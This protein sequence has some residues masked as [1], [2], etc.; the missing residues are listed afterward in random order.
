MNQE[1]LQAIFGDDFNRAHVTDFSYPPEEI[2]K[3]QVMISWA[4]SSFETYKF[5]TTNNQYFSI[6]LFNTDENNRPRRRKVLF[7]STHCIVLDD[8]K[9]KLPIEEVNR[10]PAPS[11]ILE[12]SHN[13]EQWGYILD[14][15]CTNRIQ[16]ENLLDGLVSKGLAPNG[17]DP[18]MRGVTRYVRLPD[19]YNHKRKRWIGG[20]PF[21][22]R[23]LLWEPSRKVSMQ[24][25][26]GPFGV[27]LDAS[28]RETRV[29]G[30]A[31][32]NDHPLLSSGLRIKAERSAGRFD[33]TCPWIDEH[34]DADDS[35]A[36]IFTNADGSLGF[37]CHHGACQDRTGADL[38]RS[39]GA[40]FSTRYNKWRVNRIF[41]D[42]PAQPKAEQPLDTAM[43]ELRQ[44]TPFSQ[45]ARDCAG[46]VLKIVDSMAPIERVHWHSEIRHI[47]KWGKP[48]FKSIIEGLRNSWYEK[49]TDAFIFEDVVFVGELN[50]FYDRNKRLFYSPEAYQNSF[51]HIDAEAKKRALLD[52][53]VKKVNR[54]DYAPKQPPIFIESDNVY[55][56]TWSDVTE[57][58]GVP[59]DVSRWL[60]HFDV[61]GWGEHRK[62]ILQW[63][64]FTLLY[65]ETKI[66]HM[67]LFGSKEGCGKDF[68][69]LPLI[70]ALG[71]NSKTIDGDE[72]LERYS[73]YLLGAKHLHINEAEMGEHQLAAQVGR[74]LKPLTS[75][76]P[77]TL[78]VREMYI[79]PM[80][81]R[82]IVNCTMTTNGQLPFKLTGMSRRIYALW[83]DLN[84]RDSNNEVL[85]EWEQYWNEQ[86]A[87]MYG[88]GF[89]N[90]IYYLRNNVDVSDFKYGNAPQVTDFLRSICNSSKSSLQQTVEAFIFNKVGNFGNTAITTNEAT[91]TLRSGSVIAPDLMYVDEKWINPNTVTS[92]L[93]A[94]TGIEKLSGESWRLR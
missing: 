57:I 29:D 7:A 2:P 93:S 6:S 11:W 1:F 25:L 65:P 91:A 86:W 45:E 4:G 53:L 85:P 56:N 62:H 22:C 18:G 74:K 44:Q 40:E 19:G 43:R 88:E 30:A 37:K 15:P 20:L 59:G 27:D 41:A 81:V 16:V 58:K 12:T 83:S 39:L 23:L 75:A 77:H 66:N 63:M 3:D 55:A 87:W 38:V 31:A 61:L 5:K 8:V 46:K 60:N 73:G 14:T 71:D 76:P 50:Q 47:M 24:Q 17:K 35:G 54:L 9:E 69:L 32:V 67:L 42:I 64:A 89:L 80:N 21:K 70:R 51:G 68:L 78:R 34:T 52:G 26:A 90:C 82:N 94:I 36:A 10:L 92:A 48:E 72:F 28:R 13:N 79:K 33:I 49:K 84:V